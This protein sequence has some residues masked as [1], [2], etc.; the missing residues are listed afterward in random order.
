M[1][2]IFEKSTTFVQDQNNSRISAGNSFENGGFFVYPEHVVMPQLD[3]KK[4][5][6]SENTRRLERLKNIYKNRYPMETTKVFRGRNL[7][8]TWI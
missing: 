4:L 5:R 3:K 7:F 2:E 6:E 1:L 8:T